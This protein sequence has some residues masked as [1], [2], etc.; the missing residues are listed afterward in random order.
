MSSFEAMG[1]TVATVG[2]PV[3]AE[4][5]VEAWFKHVEGRLSRFLPDS[6]VSELNDAKWL[7]SPSSLLREVLTLASAFYRETD[8]VFSPYLG[9]LLCELGYDRSF[10]QIST[11]GDVVGKTVF[12]KQEVMSFEPML[13]D[14]STGCVRLLPGVC[15]DFGGIAKGWSAQTMRGWLE[16]DGVKSGLIDAG[17]D[18]VCWGEAGHPGWEVAIADPFYPEQNKVTV[19]VK[20]GTA[21]ATSSTLKRCWTDHDDRS[22]HHIIDPS[23]SQPSRSDLVQVTIL[24]DDLSVAEVYAKCVL[25]LGSEKGMAWLKKR[26]PYLE[27]FGVRDDNSLIEGPAVG[28]YCSDWRVKI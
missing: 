18:I 6:E 2:L 20:R 22:L 14:Q 16:D 10:A 27:F 23:T 5:E 7:L 12:A 26:K 9:S 8:G 1:T 3:H 21:I 24:A 4:R 28:R 11:R 13:T 15:V 17:G 25:I 19:K